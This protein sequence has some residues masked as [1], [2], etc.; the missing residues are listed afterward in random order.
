MWLG[1]ALAAG[2]GVWA[3]WRGRWV[4]RCGALIMCSNWVLTPFVQDYRNVGLDWGILIVDALSLVGFFWLSLRSRELWTAFATAFMFL[5][6]I[7]HFAAKVTEGLSLYV[8]ISGNG[9]WGG[10]AILCCLTAGMLAQEKRR[11]RTYAHS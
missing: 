8:Y 9:I 11:K 1:N 7:G 3:L 4:E 2:L 5:A 6:V 10:Y